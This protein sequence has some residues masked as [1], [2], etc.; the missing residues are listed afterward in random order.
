MWIKQMRRAL[1]ERTK[2]SLSSWPERSRWQHSLL[3]SVVQVAGRGEMEVW[4][5]DVGLRR[6]PV[7]SGCL[8]RTFLSLAW[9]G[10]WSRPNQKRP[11]LDYPLVTELNQKLWHYPVAHVYTNPLMEHKSRPWQA[12]TSA[13]IHN[14][15]HPS[16]S[17]LQNHL[18][19]GQCIWQSITS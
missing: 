6:G 1:Q 19:Q 8:P 16:G 17:C 13:L 12:C 10:P 7:A 18:W 2:S 5:R 3:S 4:Q 9:N 15:G 11:Y 14:S